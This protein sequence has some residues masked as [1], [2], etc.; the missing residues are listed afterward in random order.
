MI[1]R[2]GP[3]GQRIRR[4]LNYPLQKGA[5]RPT[6]HQGGGFSVDQRALGGARP[7]GGGRRALLKRLRRHVR[8]RPR[9]LSPLAQGTMTHGSGREGERSR[10][11][12]FRG[13]TVGGELTGVVEDHDTVAE[14]APA[15]LGVG[16]H[17]TCRRVIGCGR[18]GA[19]RPVLAHVTF[20]FPSP[21]VCVH[22]LPSPME[23]PTSAPPTPNPSA[24]QQQGPHSC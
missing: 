18:L 16:C 19:W 8:R 17:D 4:N 23:G 12:G 14:Q 21:V 11:V 2:R 3:R 22:P 24:C 10:T 9:D 13:V 15:L 1:R 5:R 6:D 7:G 20:P